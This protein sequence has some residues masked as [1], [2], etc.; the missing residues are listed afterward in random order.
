MKSTIIIFEGADKTGKTTLINKFNKQTNFKYLVLDRFTISS[1]VYN[2]FFSRNREE[3]YKGIENVFCESFNVLLIYCYCSK[4]DNEKRLNNNNEVLPINIKD[5]EDVN[6]K[7]MENILDSNYRKVFLL[8]TTL[9]NEKDCVN[10][11]IKFV[12]DNDE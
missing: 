2:H 8:N 11:I 7:F 4:N 6:N 10:K 3:Y 5:Y 9:N 12:E 1:R